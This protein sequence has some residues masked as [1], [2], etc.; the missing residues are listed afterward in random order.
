MHAF[1]RPKFIIQIGENFFPDQSIHKQSAKLYFTKFEGKV[2]E[3]YFFLRVS[4]KI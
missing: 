2:Y 3:I 4:N 1:H